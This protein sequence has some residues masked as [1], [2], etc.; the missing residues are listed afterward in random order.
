MLQN[1]VV[2]VGKGDQSTINFKDIFDRFKQRIVESLALSDLNRST[3]K[4]MEILRRPSITD[5][6]VLNRCRF[7]TTTENIDNLQKKIE[8]LS[9]P[10]KR[11]A[12]IQMLNELGGVEAL[13]TLLLENQARQEVTKPTP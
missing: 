9:T 7:L 6:E 11:V 13:E 4:K 2:N 5:E 8:N 1:L 3:E 12:Y 10:E